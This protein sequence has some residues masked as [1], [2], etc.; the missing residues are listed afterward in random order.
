MAVLNIKNQGLNFIS[1]HNQLCD[2]GQSPPSLL[3]F[4]SLIYK[5]ILGPFQDYFDIPSAF[6]FIPFLFFLLFLCLPMCYPQ[7]PSIRE[8]KWAKN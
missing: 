3:G 2:L 8:H 1:A 7:Y 4:S 5:L 6:L